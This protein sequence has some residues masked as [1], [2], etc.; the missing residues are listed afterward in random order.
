MS[1]SP[2]GA[3]RPFATFV[4]S[5]AE[6][7]QFPAPSVKEVAFIGRS[8]V[9]KSSLLNSLVGARVAFVSRTPGRTRTVSFFD[10]RIGSSK[11]PVELRLADLPGYGYAKVSKSTAR[12]WP[13]FVE[14]YLAEREGLALCVVLVDASIPPQESDLAMV[15]RLRQVG[16]SVL[17]AATKSDRLPRSKVLSTMRA[18]ADYLG[19]EPL[20]VSSTTGDGLPELWRRVVTACGAGRRRAADDRKD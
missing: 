13:R 2:P 20:A 9:G 3:V 12:E 6:P 4:L 19:E 18:L 10:V 14:P 16:R 17:V 1:S 7:S 8:N 15:Q 5:A 11:G